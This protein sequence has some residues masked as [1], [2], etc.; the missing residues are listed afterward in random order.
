MRETEVV[1]PVP[2]PPEPT[3]GRGRPATAAVAGVLL[4]LA[5]LTGGVVWALQDGAAV[6]A[7]AAAPLPPVAGPAPARTIPGPPTPTSSGPTA[8]VGGGTAS[9]APAPPPAGG[10]AVPPPEAA[11]GPP[12]WPAV[13]AEL[14]AHRGQAWA[15][16]DLS[17]LAQVYEAGSTALAVDTAALQG[18]T[19]QGLTATGVRHEV[20]SVAA[21]EVTADRARLRVV[22]AL[23]PQQV[24]D[25]S[26][27]VVQDLPGRGAAAFDVVLARTPDGWRVAAVAPA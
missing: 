19:G 18:L 5:L 10:S 3:R 6:A 13:L 22:D 12:A 11:P 23:G 7:R 24:R 27:A 26:G 9:S 1:R 4:V 21:A 25:R 17:L 14:D 15:R 2:E 16:G 8:P 20:R